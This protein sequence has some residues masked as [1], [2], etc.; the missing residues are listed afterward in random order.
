MDKER[1]CA[2][3]RFKRYEVSTFGR[4]RVI[5]NGRILNPMRRG[6]HLWVLMLSD[7]RN[8]REWARVCLMSLTCFKPKGKILGSVWHIDNDPC[9][10]HIDN[11]IWIDRTE[12]N[13]RRY[14]FK[15]TKKKPNYKLLKP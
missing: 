14:A 13:D 8:V 7:D 15:R 11:L 10:N 5:H 3:P 1:W 12:F 6:R 2:I 4:V 9:N